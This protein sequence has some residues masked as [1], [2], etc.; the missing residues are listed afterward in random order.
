MEK[1]R[2]IYLY[3]VFKNADGFFNRKKETFRI[4]GKRC[5]KTTLKKVNALMYNANLRRR[6]LLKKVGQKTFAAGGALALGHNPFVADNLH[7]RGKNTK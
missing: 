6:E 3:K 2:T 4:R 7:F 5:K 1:G